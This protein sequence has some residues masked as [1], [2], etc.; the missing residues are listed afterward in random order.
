MADV[1]VL[2]KQLNDVFGKQAPKMPEGG[3][4]FFVEW[5]PI[6]TLIGAVLS[7]FS[8][9]TLWQSAN[10]VNELV[11]WVNDV[12]RAYGGNKVSTGDV[13]LWVWLAVGF[14]AVQAVIYFMAYNPLKARQKKGWDLL[15]YVTLLSVAYSVVML[16]INGRGFGSLVLG[17]LGT[18]IG[19]WILF[20]IRPA[21]LGKHAAEST[22]K[23]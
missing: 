13:T 11:D 7:V 14:T 16:F 10:R 3:K 15:F 18:A 9:W 17:L 5:L 6:L 23:E 4:K 22:P 21:Y 12:S 2:E 19:W 20:Q 1:S 8:A